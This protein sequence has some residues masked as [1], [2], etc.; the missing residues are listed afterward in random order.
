[1]TLKLIQFKKTQ[2]KKEHIFFILLRSHT[3]VH[4][5]IRSHTYTLLACRDDALCIL[6]FEEKKSTWICICYICTER[7]R[8]SKENV[9]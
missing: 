3:Y 7:E 2:I 6:V 9:H 5:Y 8:E 4:K 1:M